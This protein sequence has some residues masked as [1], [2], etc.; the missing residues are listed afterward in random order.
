MSERLISSDSPLPPAETA[1]LRRIFAG[2]IPAS[3]EYGVPGADDG[4]IF[5]DILVTGRTMLPQIASALREM[6]EQDSQQEQ[7]AS[8]SAADDQAVAWFRRTH[9]EVCGLLVALAVQCYYRDDRVMAS[10]QMEARPPFPMGYELEEDDWSVLEPVRQR[11]PIYRDVS[12][13]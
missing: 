8:N 5:A 10:L 3:T 9:A 1:A 2:M 11:G 4:N 12:K 7:T 6:I 13:L